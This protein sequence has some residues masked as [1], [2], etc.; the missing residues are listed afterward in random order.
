M[1]SKLFRLENIMKKIFEQVEKNPESAKDLRKFMEYYLPTTTKL[2]RAYVDLDKQPEVDN[3]RKTKKEIESSLD[4]INDA[5]E[6][7]LDDM[8][9]DV[10]WDISSD[11]SVMKTMMAQDGL[12]QTATSGGAMQ[13][14]G[15]MAMQA[16]EEEH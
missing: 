5:F 13:A 4:V 3:I 14:S 16:M 9:Q 11:I 2:L 6:Q 7:L 10:A 8:F 15:G 1:S 12:V